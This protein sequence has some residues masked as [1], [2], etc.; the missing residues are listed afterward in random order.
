[1]KEL[2]IGD[3]VKM[4]TCKEI[5]DKD[6]LWEIMQLAGVHIVIRNVGD[7]CRSQCVGS[8]PFDSSLVVK[9]L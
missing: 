1:M 5:Q 9:V 6:D 4:K 2:K 3:I 8:H 7:F